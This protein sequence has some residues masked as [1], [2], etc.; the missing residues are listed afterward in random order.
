MKNFVLKKPKLQK[1]DLKEFSN[2]YIYGRTKLRPMKEE[3]ES[4]FQEVLKD[5]GVKLD[6]Y[7]FARLVAF[8]YMTRGPGT[9]IANFKSWTGSFIFPEPIAS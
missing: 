8:R 9:S 1:E 5:Y 6:P 7:A 2:F 4:I 3:F